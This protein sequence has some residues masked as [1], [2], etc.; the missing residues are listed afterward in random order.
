MNSN[1][2]QLINKEKLTNLTE[3]S[4]NERIWQ[5]T[6]DSESLVKPGITIKIRLLSCI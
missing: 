3:G 1:V 2:L 6:A 4:E 5:L